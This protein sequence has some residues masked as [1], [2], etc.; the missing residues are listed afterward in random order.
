LEKKILC[1]RRDTFSITKL[2]LI[3]EIISQCDVKHIMTLSTKTSVLTVLTY[4][5]TSNLHSSSYWTRFNTRDNFCFGYLLNLHLSVLSIALARSSTILCV[6]RE[7]T[8]IKTYNFR[9]CNNNLPINMQI[10]MT[11]KVKIYLY[12]NEQCIYCC[13]LS[14]M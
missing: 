12:Q 1:S 6:I 3:H 4:I 13:S 5:I 9:N 14:S 7:I 8:C 2:K 10:S 11:L